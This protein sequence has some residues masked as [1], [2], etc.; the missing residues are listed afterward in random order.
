LPPEPV[1]FGPHSYDPG[2]SP[3]LLFWTIQ[4]PNHAVE[5]DLDEGTAVL[6]LKNICSVFDSFTV[7]NSL[8]IR[9]ALG[10]VGA[11]VESLRVEWSGITKSFLSFS[12]TAEKFTGN[13][14]E[15]S[16][17]IAVTTRT[18]ATSPPFTPA[19]QDGF[20]FV[21]DPTTTVTNF[22]QIGSERNGLFFS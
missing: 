15:T 4:I 11:V 6:S 20:R 18:P 5:I 21:S 1:G 22:A 16:A 7:A 17:K 14:F 10:F 9:H 12:S 19:V 8:D 3:T 13:F 2:T